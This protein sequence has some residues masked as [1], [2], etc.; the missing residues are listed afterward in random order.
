MAGRIRMDPLTKFWQNKRKEIFHL[1]HEALTKVLYR[2]PRLL[3]DRYTWIL[4][5]VCNLNCAFCFQRRDYRQDHM[6]LKDWLALARQLPRYAR[7]TLTGGEPL[8]FPQ[9]KEIF[10][11][12]AQRYDCNLI[13]NG[14]LLTEKWIDLFLSYPRLRVL[15]ISVDDI[16]NRIREVTPAQWQRVETLLRYFVYRRREW[17]SRC[18][19]E[20]KTVI[21]DE[22]ADDLLRIH[23]Y[24]MERLS[25]DHHSLMFLKGSPLQHADYMFAFEDMFRP[26]QAPVYQKFETI[27]RELRRIQE[28]NSQTGKTAF[29]HP[30]VGR[31]T[32]CRDLPDLNYLNERGFCKEHFR[33]CPFPWSSVHINAD[34]N[35]F[36]CMAIPMGNV[37]TTPLREIIHGKDFMRFKQVIHREGTVPGCHRCGWLRP[38]KERL[39]SKTPFPSKM[40]QEQ[41]AYV[42]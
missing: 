34:G 14:L 6:E 30:K 24:C 23:Q 35:L 26:A 3:P 36:P 37:K 28:Y 32:A 42:Y 20:A 2:F 1:K 38:V 8:M 33:P 29:L 27:V 5:N 39:Q 13:T 19:L 18:L 7:V 16:G 12:V 25:C 22:N 41:S 11:Y 10:T 9:F 17:G 31:L 15:A 21:L 4:T 40:I